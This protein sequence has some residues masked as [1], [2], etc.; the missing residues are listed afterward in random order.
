MG[1]KMFNR[2][3]VVAGAL[4]I[5]V[6]LGAVYIWSVFQSPLLEYFPEWSNTQVTMPAQIVLAC[7]A[8]AVIF[9]GRFQDRYGPRI[10]ATFGGVILGT[11]MVLARFADQFEPG[12]ALIWLILTYAVLGGFGIGVAYVCPI[13][14]C[15][16]WFPDKRGLVTGLA[17]AGRPLSSVFLRALL[18]SFNSCILRLL[19][20][21]FPLQSPAPEKNQYFYT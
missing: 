1:N 8:I 16:K 9:G 5:Q 17:V 18:H 2:W 13:A 4:V 7:F 10:V 20:A 6:S 19:L 21:V 14:T 15:V 12:F 11:G 3:W